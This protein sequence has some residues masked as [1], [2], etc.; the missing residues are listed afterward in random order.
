MSGL[1]LFAVGMGLIAIIA[2]PD[3]AW[4]AFLAPQVIAGVGMG[5]TFAPMTTV[6]MRDIDRRMAGS[7]SGVFNTTRQV[8]SVIGTAGVGALLENRLVAG[9]TS[10]A[11]HFT[12][13]RSSTAT[14]KLVTGL[15]AAAKSGLEVGSGQKPTGLA[16]MIFTHG[17]VEAMRPTML[18]PIALLIVAAASCLLLKRRTQPAGPQAATPQPPATVDGAQEPT[19]ALG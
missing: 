19:T 8:G 6:A 10:Q 7:A 11:E 12:V 1:V 18:T 13:G 4:T 2:Q 16:G 17:F 9:L 14:I 15:R 5:C 3:S